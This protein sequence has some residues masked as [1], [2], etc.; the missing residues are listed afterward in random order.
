MNGLA[1]LAAGLVDSALRSG[2]DAADAV[3]MRDETVAVDRRLGKL[4]SLERSESVSLGLR[5]LIGCRQASVAASDPSQRTCGELVGRAVA[6]ARAAPEDRFAGL[7][8]AELLAGDLPDLDLDG[9]GEP[10]TSV[11]IDLA[12]EAEEAALAVKGIT[13]SDGA[14]AH[15]R[16]TASVLVTSNGFSGSSSRTMTG[17]GVAV[18]AGDEGGRQT[19]HAS[20]QARHLGDLPPPAAV[21]EEAARRA[22]ARLDPRTLPTGRMPLV[23]DPRTARSLIAHLPGFIAGPAIARGTSWMKDSLDEQVFARGVTIAED[24]FIRRGLASRP[25]DGEGLAPRPRKLVDDGVLTTWLLDCRSARQLGLQ[26]TGHAVRGAGGPPSTGTANLWLEAGEVSPDEMMADI[27][28]G[29]YITELG[30]H[31]VNPVTGDYSRSAAGARIVDGRLDH[32]V[33]GI[34]VAGN[35]AAMYAD[36]RPAS[37]LEFRAATNAPSVRIDTMTVAGGSGR[38]GS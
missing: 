17:L 7:A 38:Q 12:G 30:G 26:P 18:I 19:D 6:M 34:T 10:E 20:R 31:G 8:A 11:L 23:F 27:G 15:W 35:L 5:V 22:V 24:P 3:V 9:G 4:E 2:A 28:E 21:G 29:L 14:G 1:D 36:L 32:A 25:Y 13:N 16:R 37:D 33:D